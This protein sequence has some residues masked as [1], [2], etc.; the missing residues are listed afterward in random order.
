MEKEKYSNPNPVVT[1]NDNTFR[2]PT[3]TVVTCGFAGTPIATIDAQMVDNK[4]LKEITFSGGKHKLEGTYVKLRNVAPPNILPPEETSANNFKYSSGDDKFEAVMIYY[5]I[6]TIQRYI[7]SLG[8]TTARNSQIPADHHDNSLSGHGAFYAGLGDK[9][10]HFGDSEDCRPDRGEDA[11]AMVHEYGHAIQDDQVPGW[12]VQNPITGRE[13]SGAMGEG[14]GDILA[15]VYFAEKGGG[16][17][18]Q[19]F[20]DWVFAPNGLRHS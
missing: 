18:R 14:F 6:D 17:Q 2:D 15:C 9:G 3:A 4:D 12:G 7:Q 16:F 8:I 5:H 20:E 11:D 1:A 10:I 13:E 19:V